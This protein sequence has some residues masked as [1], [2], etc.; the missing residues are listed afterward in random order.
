[1]V[2]AQF[3]AAPSPHATHFPKDEEKLDLILSSGTLCIDG[4]G[5]KTHLVA[6][7][8]NGKRLAVFQEGIEKDAIKLEMGSNVG[9]IHEEG[10]RAVFKTLFERVQI[11]PK[12]QNLSEVLSHYKIIAAMAGVGSDENRAIVMALF[13]EF[14]ARKE[15][16]QLLTD[17]DA[18]ISLLPGSRGIVIISGTGSFVKGKDGAKDYPEGGLGWYLGDE[19]SG[20]EISKFALKKGLEDELR[21]G[22][23]TALT[24][25]LRSHFKVEKLRTVLLKLNAK[26]MPPSE[27]ATA[28]PLVFEAAQRGDPVAKS[29]I[30]KSAKR[31]NRLLG[32]VLEKSN[33]SGCELHL[34]GGVFTNESAQ[35]FIDKVDGGLLKGRSIRIVN[36]SLENV[37]LELVQASLDKPG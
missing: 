8:R 14:G 11:G 31:L 20:H 16:V 33:L 6:V 36:R 7:D 2:Q 30:D 24:T 32:R 3:N 17:I 26:Q 37:A 13:N 5:S 9:T 12:K 1:M 4:G 27:L 28:C 19:G 29:I 34:R 22:E 25:I 21:N 10:L 15:R 23:K 35:S 18:A